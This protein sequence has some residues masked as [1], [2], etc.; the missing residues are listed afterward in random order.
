MEVDQA[1]I[2]F[3]PID[4]GDGP[5]FAKVVQYQREYMAG[6]QSFLDARYGEALWH[7]RKADQI[8]RSKPEW[9][10]SR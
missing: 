9:T 3:S 7:L 5:N 4:D 8:I 6:R 10:E 2:F 1:S